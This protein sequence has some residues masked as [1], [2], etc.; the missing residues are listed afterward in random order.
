MQISWRELF[1]IKADQKPQSF[2]P[3]K[4]LYGIDLGF[5]TSKTE[6]LI[7]SIIHNNIYRT[8]SYYDFASILGMLGFKLLA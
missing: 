2:S 8:Y 1:L 3:C 6:L 5:V 7:A 4:N